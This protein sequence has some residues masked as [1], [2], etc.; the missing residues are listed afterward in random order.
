M[1]T[2]YD[3]STGRMAVRRR[4]ISPEDLNH[5]Y[6]IVLDTSERRMLGGMSD[7]LR[8][9]TWKLWQDRPDV[10]LHEVHRVYPMPD[11]VIRRVF[12]PREELD[13]LQREDR[14]LQI[15]EGLGGAEAVNAAGA[16]SAAG[17]GGPSGAMPGAE[18][19]AEDTGMGGM[20]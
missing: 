17:A 11:M 10:R 19:V 3:E 1:H 8:L 6:K 9:E 4:M 13:R 18:A 2:A 15:A 12:K 14:Q 16:A 20:A 5:G 7:Q